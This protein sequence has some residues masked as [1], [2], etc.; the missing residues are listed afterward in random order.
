MAKKAIPKEPIQNVS[1][2]M[3]YEGYMIIVE[4][5]ID[6]YRVVV[7]KNGLYCVSFIDKKDKGIKQAK[8]Y[9]DAAV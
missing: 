2:F 8:E 3:E 9:I 4:P 6:D 5:L 1:D 7:A